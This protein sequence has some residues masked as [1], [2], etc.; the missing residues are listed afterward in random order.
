MKACTK[1]SLVQAVDRSVLDWQ[2]KGC[3]RGSL[4]LVKLTLTALP[5]AEKRK[6]KRKSNLL[7]PGWK[8]MKENEWPSVKLTKERCREV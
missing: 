5:L 1:F 4:A 3:T 6:N 7:V 2:I 8:L